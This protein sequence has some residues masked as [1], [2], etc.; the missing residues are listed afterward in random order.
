ML[1][2]MIYVKDMIKTGVAA[3]EPWDPQDKNMLCFD[4]PWAS[5]YEILEVDLF[6]W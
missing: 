1:H 5:G 2:L 4:Y 6:H 3:C